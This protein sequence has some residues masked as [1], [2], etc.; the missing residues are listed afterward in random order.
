MIRGTTPTITLKYKN[1]AGQY[2][3]LS[4]YNVFITLED[5]TQHQITFKNDR[6]TFNQDNS[7]QFTMTQAETLS[8]HGNKIEIQLRAKATTG[9]AIASDVKNVSLA[10]ILMDGEI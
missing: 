4:T 8:L 6:I 2:V 9:E 1:S 5:N 3:D 7:F 10:Q